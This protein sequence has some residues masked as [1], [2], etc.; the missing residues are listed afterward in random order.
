MKSLL[1]RVRHA[2]KIHKIPHTSMPLLSFDWRRQEGRGYAKKNLTLHA[3]AAIVIRLAMRR[4]RRIALVTLM[5]SALAVVRGRATIFRRRLSLV[6]RHV[7]G[8]VRSIGMLPRIVQR[9]GR[10]HCWVHSLMASVFVLRRG[11]VLGCGLLFLVVVVFHLVNRIHAILL[12]GF[13]FKVLLFF[14]RQLLQ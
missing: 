14:G 7:M 9:Y 4:R 10:N 8:R 11:K 13:T 5:R 12:I 2:T 6:I 1:T 3:H